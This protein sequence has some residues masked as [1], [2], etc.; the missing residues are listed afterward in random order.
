MR[1]TERSE[2][3]REVRERERDGE[4]DI[5]EN[6]GKHGGWSYNAYIK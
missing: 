6:E 2:R 5:R 4:R 3:D 1:G